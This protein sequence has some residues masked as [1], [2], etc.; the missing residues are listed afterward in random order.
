[1]QRFL[2]LLAMIAL[3]LLLS[4]CA[5]SKERALERYYDPRGLFTAELPAA[6]DVQVVEPQNATSG[7]SIV[8]GVTSIPAAPSPSS[9]AA[10]GLGDVTAQQGDVTVYQVLVVSSQVPT[11]LQELASVQ[12]DDPNADLRSRETTTVDGDEALLVVSDYAATDTNGPYTLASA[13]VLSKG[14]GYQIFA[15]F[16]VGTWE[17]ERDS[18][19]DVLRSFRTEVSPGVPLAPLS[20]PGA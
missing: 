16:P 10:T 3:A 5:G 20:D 14:L 9:G 11:T 17:S 8:S 15:A 19:L 4:G 18:F 1:M 12:L 13:S 6:N 2:P 7:P